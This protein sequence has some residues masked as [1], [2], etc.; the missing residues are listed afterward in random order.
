MNFSG[1]LSWRKRRAKVN[2]FWVGPRGRL[3]S[4]FSVCPSWYSAWQIRSKIATLSPR[5]KARPSLLQIRLMCCQMEAIFSPR[6]NFSFPPRR[7]SLNICYTIAVVGFVLFPRYPLLVGTEIII[8][9]F[10][11]NS[12]MWFFLSF[13]ST[14]RVVMGEWRYDLSCW[15]GGKELYVPSYIV[16]FLDMFALCYYNFIWLKWL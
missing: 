15:R 12:F 11:S 5:D 16:L 4:P 3:F 6:S 8:S 9:R 1:S 7:L 10:S 13:F 2:V 14:A